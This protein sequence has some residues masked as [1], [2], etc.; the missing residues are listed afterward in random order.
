MVNS[1]THVYIEKNSNATIIEKTI[2]LA[3]KSV[4]INTQH[5]VKAHPQSELHFHKMTMNSS[6]D[7]YFEHFHASLLSSALHFSMYTTGSSYHRIETNMLLHDKNANIEFSGMMIPFA[8][9]HID[10]VSHIIHMAPL[11]QSEQLMQSFICDHGHSSFL[12]KV[13]VNEHAYKTDASLKSQHLLL[14]SQG[15]ADSAPQFE[16]HNDDVKCTHGATIS[17]LDENTLFYLQ[18]R[19]FSLSQS[20]SLIIHALMDKILL[21]IENAPVRADFYHFIKECLYDL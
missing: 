15:K 17:G 1:Q 8:K 10:W 20:K 5:F 19:G 16:I 3:K 9:S 18:S 14:G 4:L 11:C 2:S 13:S 12:G 7:Y 21:N 6:S